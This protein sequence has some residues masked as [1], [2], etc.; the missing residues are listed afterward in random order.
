MK[1][2]YLYYLLFFMGSLLPFLIVEL[3]FQEWVTIG[4]I[5]IIVGVVLTLCISYEYFNV[6]FIHRLDVRN[7]EIDYLN[8]I[9]KKENT[10]WVSS[11]F[12]GKTYGNNQILIS[13]MIF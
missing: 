13:N 7:K 10:G 5:A 3:C 2:I 1:K 8:W 12:L 11:Y 6:K 4:I 9:N